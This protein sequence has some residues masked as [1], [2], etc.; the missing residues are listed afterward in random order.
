MISFR[1]F[2]NLTLSDTVCDESAVDL[3]FIIG[4]FHNQT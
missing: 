1:P 4:Q 2:Q 3:K